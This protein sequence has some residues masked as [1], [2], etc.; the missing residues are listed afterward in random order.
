MLFNKS[1]TTLPLTA[2]LLTL[3]FLSPA[4]GITSNFGAESSTGAVNIAGKFSLAEAGS[5]TDQASLGQGIASRNLLA[6]GQGQSSVTDSISGR[7]SSG[8]SFSI[9]KTACVDGE[10]QT[11]SSAAATPAGGLLS[12][13]TDLSGDGGLFAIKSASSENKIAAAA[14]FSDDGFLSSTMSGAAQGRSALGGD[15]Q[16]MGVSCFDEEA[17]SVLSSGEIGM[18]VSGLYMSRDKLQK[19]GLAA[20]ND[21]LSGRTAGTDYGIIPPGYI[22]PGTTTYGYY[23]DP[24]AY[25]LQGYRWLSDPQLKLYLRQDTAL[26]GEG[27]DSAL[28]ANEIAA[29]ANTWDNVAK[30]NLFAD[31]DLVTKSGL[32]FS[33][34]RYDGRNVHAWKKVS[35]DALAYSRTYYTQNSLYKVNGY[36]RALESDVVYNTRWGWTTVQDNAV[37]VRDSRGNAIPGYSI[38]DLQSVAAHELGHTLGMGDTYLHSLYKY[39]LAQI[40]GFYDDPGPGYYTTYPALNNPQRWLGEGDMSGIRKLY[41]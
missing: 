34:D 28:A 20:R 36:F 15:A 40:M 29:A 27:L 14:V 10:L 35:S 26:S 3:L 37:L 8:Q 9:S 38:L 39:D 41:G 16:V 33:A 30:E 11:S 18:T 23:N 25:V 22:P 17:A 5:L 1:T 19:F 13:E 24:R 7:D 31:I 4:S 21:E 12:Q 32:L 6:T 2:V